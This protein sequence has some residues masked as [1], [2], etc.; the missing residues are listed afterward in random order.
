MI[1]SISEDLPVGLQH[2]KL[3]IEFSVEYI[4]EYNSSGS[5]VKKQSLGGDV[6]DGPRFSIQT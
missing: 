4:I 2:P 1:V 3:G 5:W 6:I